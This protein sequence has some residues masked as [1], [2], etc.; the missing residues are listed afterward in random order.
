MDGFFYEYMSIFER[1]R[2]VQIIIRFVKVEL[3]YLL[4]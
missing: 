4:A 1:M 3:T 2:A